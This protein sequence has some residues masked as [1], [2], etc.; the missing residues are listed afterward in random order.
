MQSLEHPRERAAVLDTNSDVFFEIL[1]GA[2]KARRVLVPLN[3]RLAPAEMVDIIND[4]GV[5]LLF[6]GPEFLPVA[7][8]LRPSCPGVRQVVTLG[9]HHA[10]M[11][12]YTGWRDR[13]TAS[14]PH[15]PVGRSEVVLLVYTSGTTGRPKGAELTHEN[16]LTNAPLLEVEYGSSPGSDTGLVCLPLFHV[17]GC[18]WG[19]SCLYAGAGIVI[20]RRVTPVDVLCAIAEHKVTKTLLVPAIIQLLLDAPGREAYDVSSLDL[21]LYGA[22]PISEGVLCRALSTFDCHFGQVYGLTETTGAITYLPPQDHD[23]INPA[24]LQSCGKPLSHAQIRVVDANGGDVPQ[25]QIGEIVC[26]TAQN[27]KG[28]W[29]C[30][31]ETKAVLRGEWLHTGDA[32]Y[33]DADGYLYIHDRIKDMIVSGGENVF[34][35][36]VE[37]VLSSH[38]GVADVAVIGV[39]DDRWGELAKAF[40]VRKEG[41]TVSAE[42]LV[43]FCRQ[44]IAG[45]KVPRSVDFVGSLQRN[46]A[47]KLLKQELRAPYWAGRTRAVN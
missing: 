5:G 27:M 1:F 29:N 34:P 37:R 39:P 13:Q 40:V 30:P 16:L 38:P 22:S 15:V 8:A 17:S 45:Y 7:E 28:Y 44:R 26:R 9:G 41:V 46:A 4:A 10:G 12:D 35:A 6:V 11:E 2:A 19:L 32:G 18:L 42:D 47:G 20:L 14:D 21:I 36:E 43:A 23:L 31:D 24:R 3:N 33:L 25:G